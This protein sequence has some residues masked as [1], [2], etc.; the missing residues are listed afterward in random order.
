[1]DDM[2]SIFSQ[3]FSEGILPN[4]KALI[5]FFMN[6]GKFLGVCVIILPLLGRLI[7]IFRK[8]F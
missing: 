3:V 2:F 8:L 4:C 5:D 6:E 1:M 7:N